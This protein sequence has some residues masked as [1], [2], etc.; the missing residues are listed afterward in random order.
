M[1]IALSFCNIQHVK[2]MDVEIDL[3]NSEIACI[4]GRNGCGKTTLI[5]ALKNVIDATTFSETAAPN[6]F[7]VSSQIKYAI[8][9]EEITYTYNSKLKA[10]DSKQTLNNRNLLTVE[11]PI[12]NGERFK[13]FQTLGAVDESL[14][15]SIVEQSYQSA[16]ELIELYSRLY[17]LFESPHRFSD[18]K[19]IKLKGRDYYFILQP[20]DFYIRQDYFSSGEYFVLELYRLACMSNRL[21][22][23]DELDI[24]LDAAAQVKLLCLLR[25]ILKR[26]KSKI[27]FTTH[28]LALMKTLKPKEL[29]FMENHSG[30]VTIEQRSYSFVKASL[31]GF[32]GWDRVILVEDKMAKKFIDWLLKDLSNLCLYN[33]IYIG[34]HQNVF[35]LYRRNGHENYFDVSNDSVICCLDGDQSAKDKYQRDGIM[36]LPFDSVEQK[37]AELHDAGKLPNK[38]PN[39]ERF[40]SRDRSKKITDQLIGKRKGYKS[41]MSIDEGFQHIFDADVSVI[42]KFRKELVDFLRD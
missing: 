15:A 23:V 4:V 12:P 5:R 6:I 36:F 8:N 37:L 34:G 1:N 10:L 3:S 27:L 13:Y 9:G 35:D 17:H 30:N 7:K 39:H 25:P 19:T 18:L 2:S 22:V 28:S 41:M 32:K 42:D 16:D 38:V 20:N 14:R 21:I 26:S 11:L 29:Y 40:T 24:S 31:F 33:I